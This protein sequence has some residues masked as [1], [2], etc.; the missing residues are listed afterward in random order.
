MFIF[1]I[2]PF[3]MKR[4]GTSS[5]NPFT[6]ELLYNRIGCL[7]STVIACKGKVSC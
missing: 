7:L 4:R 5:Q 2:S 3:C 6:A 1:E